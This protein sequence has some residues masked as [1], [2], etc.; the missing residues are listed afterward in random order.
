MNEASE[1]GNLDDVVDTIT[2]FEKSPDQKRLAKFE[3]TWKQVQ[4]WGPET[5]RLIEDPKMRKKAIEIA[6]DMG[7]FIVRLSAR[8]RR[9]E[10]PIEA[11]EVEK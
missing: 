10:F 11:V 4:W 2:S 8:M 7:A 6:T 3:K 9:E 5:F 1:E